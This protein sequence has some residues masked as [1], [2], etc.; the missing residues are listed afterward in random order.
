MHEQRGEYSLVPIWPAA[1]Y[2]NFSSTQSPSFHLQGAVSE[3]RARQTFASDPRSG[4][5][6]A[7]LRVADL[8]AGMGSVRSRRYY[9]AYSIR[10]QYKSLLR[11]THDEEI[12]R[13]WRLRRETSSWPVEPVPTYTLC[14]TA[15]RT[16]LRL[17]Q[18]SHI[19]LWNLSQWF[20]RRWDS[21]SILL[22]GE[23]ASLVNMKFSRIFTVSTSNIFENKKFQN[24][25]G[26]K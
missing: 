24:R 6:A 18:S 7:G 9:P 3:A 17:C 23:Q 22:Q 20:Y 16:I 21:L 25:E 1:T 26:K 15:P 8:Q 12:E 5:G 10:K 13:R 11:T 2:R 14:I 4:S 19:L